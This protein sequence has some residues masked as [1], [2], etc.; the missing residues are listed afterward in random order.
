MQTAQ[1]ETPTCGSNHTVG[2]NT[3]NTAQLSAIR[4]DGASTT[5]GHQYVQD[6]ALQ[7]AQM[8]L[9][10]AATFAEFHCKKPLFEKRMGSGATAVLV[11]F[12]WPG[13]LAVYDPNT[14]EALAR[15]APGCPKSLQK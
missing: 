14:G 8:R 12:E 10:Q 4:H 2:V 15:S 9:V 11:R 13:V 6:L 7:A 1:K 3:S 5:A